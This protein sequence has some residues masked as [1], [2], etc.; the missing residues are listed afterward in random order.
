MAQIERNW[1]K[2]YQTGKCGGERKKNPSANPGIVKSHM[3]NGTYLL[4]TNKHKFS[5]ATVSATC[6]RCGLTDEDITHMLLDSPALYSQRK[7]FCSKVRSL[8]MGYIGI[9]QW[10]T[11]LADEDITHM[12][13]DCPALYSQRKL[14]C[15]KVK[16]LVMGYIGI[17]QWRTM[18]NTM[19]NI[20]EL[21]TD[22]SIFPVFACESQVKEVAKASS[23]LCYRLHLKRIHKLK[24]E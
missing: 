18:F 22:C 13:L 23:E 1:H 6:K 14:F 19:L 12:L 21:L 5:E 24:G 10:R 20:I 4:Q 8:V 3:L 7:L 2:K 15:S 9:D 17:D 16:S 11:M